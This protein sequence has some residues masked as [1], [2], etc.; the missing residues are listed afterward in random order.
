MFSE[1]TESIT[2]TVEPVFLEQQS[3]L[4]EG[5][6]VW[7]YHV[8]IENGGRET[9]QLV[10]RHWQITDA[11]GQR[12]DVRGPG[13]VG[14]QPILDPGA[15]FEYTS[16]CPLKTPSGFMVGSYEMERR[17]GSRFLIRIPMFSLDSP[18]AVSQIH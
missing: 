17:D 13:V 12:E 15:S 9:V 16:G 10:N 5:R 11:R 2:V 7:A 14:E 1:T 3:S 8:R 18:Y 6:F 4:A